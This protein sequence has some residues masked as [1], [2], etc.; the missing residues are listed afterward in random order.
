MSTRQA[1]EG[2]NRHDLLVQLVRERENQLLDIGWPGEDTTINAD[3][4]ASLIEEV[5]DTVGAR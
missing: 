2:L 1:L 4:V 3:A 5:L